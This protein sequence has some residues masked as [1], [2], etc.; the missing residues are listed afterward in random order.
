MQVYVGC[1]AQGVCHG[2]IRIR[3]EPRLKASPQRAGDWVN[4]QELVPTERKGKA[5]SN[6]IERNGRSGRQC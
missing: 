6:G 4:I 3:V 2:E 1:V 5:G